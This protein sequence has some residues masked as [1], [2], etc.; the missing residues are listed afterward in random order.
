MKPPFK[1]SELYQANY[2]Q[3]KGKK[4]TNNQGGT[5]SGKTYSIL[6][7]LIMKAWENPNTVITVVGQDI[8]NLKKG[9]HRDLET[10]I[11]GSKAVQHQIAEHN[12]T[13]RIYKFKNGSIIEF[14]S[15]DDEQDAK[16]GKRDFLF[17]NEANGVDEKV[18]EQLYIRTR[19]YTWI[20]YNPSAEFWVNEKIIGKAH[21]RT[22][23]STFYHNPFLDT[24]TL[25]KILGYEDTPENRSKGT[26]DKYRWKVYGLG[27]FAPMEGAIYPNWIELDFPQH[28]PHIWVM[29]FGYSNDPTT[30]DKMALDNERIYLDERLNAPKLSTQQIIDILAETVPP[31]ELIVADSA[32][33]RLIN[34]VAEAGFN[35]VPS[36][37]G[38]DSVRAGI[39][40]AQDYQICVTNTSH[41]IKK[42]LNNYVW[43]DKRSNTPI[44]AFNHH[45]DPMRYGLQELTATRAR[46]FSG[47]RV[48]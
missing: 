43:H 18:F 28:L 25:E 40:K 9:A 46:G 48:M 22:I 8:P 5:S 34:D 32:E 35:I 41:N 27:E 42:E 20:D 12:K 44:D 31:D 19:K 10:I 33:P 16:N 11:S 14:N 26:V 38:Q 47:V 13:D 37:K 1:V 3:P 45:L 6:Q 7:V 39:K 21:V 30:L 36:Q 2:E 24:E 4:I 23:K 17:V 15:Y 29:D